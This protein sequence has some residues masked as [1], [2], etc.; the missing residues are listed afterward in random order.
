MNQLQISCEKN[1]FTNVELRLAALGDERTAARFYLSTHSQ[2]SSLYNMLSRLGPHEVTFV[3]QVR[4][5]DELAS[6]K[7]DLSRLR[8]VKL[9]LEGGELEALQGAQN[10]LDL[11]DPPA[12]LV[13]LNTVARADGRS[14]VGEVRRMFQVRHFA[15]FLIEASR[16]YLRFS[17][18]RLGTL[19]EDFFENLAVD[20]LFVKPGSTSFQRV[21]PLFGK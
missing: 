9:D 3:Q 5:D 17:L 2:L 16:F 12:F 19:P 11:P 14:A 21:Q 8:L 13:E 10:L 4:L 20:A 7:W 6:A 18:P 15:E 1:A